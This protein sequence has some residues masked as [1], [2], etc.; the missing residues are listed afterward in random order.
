MTT[1]AEIQ[2]RI[3]RK[4]ERLGKLRRM[5]AQIDAGTL[6]KFEAMDD[7]GQR[8]VFDADPALFR[9]HMETIHERNLAKLIGGPGQ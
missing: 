5:K 9:Q 2:E 3:E 8:N 4:Q 1:E 7:P 6:E